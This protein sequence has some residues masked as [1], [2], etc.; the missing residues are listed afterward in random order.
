MRGN[1]VLIKI[2]RSNSSSFA[3]PASELEPRED[4]V[5]TMFKEHYRKSGHSGCAGKVPSGRRTLGRRFNWCK[6]T[7]TVTIKG[8][9]YC[10]KHAKQQQAG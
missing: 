5:E 9:P 7:P 3:V 10:I 4:P 6:G 8:L 2:E 1:K